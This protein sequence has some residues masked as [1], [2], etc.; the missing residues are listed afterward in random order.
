MSSLTDSICKVLL[1]PTQYIDYCAGQYLQ[2]LLKTG[3]LSFSIANA[4]LGEKHYELH[5]RH[6][7]DNPCHQDLLQ[8]LRTQG[9]L[10]LQLPFGVCDMRALDPQRPIVF[11]A[12]G[13]GFAPIKAMLEQLVA[14]G[15]RRLLELFWGARTT[16]DLYLDEMVLRMQADMSHFRYFAQRKHTNQDS[17]LR[18]LLSQ[19]PQD[20]GDWQFVLSGPFD[21]VY[22]LRDALVSAGVARECLFADAF[23]FET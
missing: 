8:T 11:V 16:S 20:L 19:H 12:G 18:L 15:D 4:P 21:M 1:T 10:T 22:H 13:T 9:T 7:A 2:I 14:D 6:S 3:A 23:Q 17:L 5:I